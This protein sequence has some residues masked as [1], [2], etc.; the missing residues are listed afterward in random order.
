MGPELGQ[1]GGREHFLNDH[2]GGL[3]VF[4]ACGLDMEGAKDAA[5]AEPVAAIRF[6]RRS[7]LHFPARWIPE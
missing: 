6:G 4:E 7:V 1:S 2:S 3:I 5:I